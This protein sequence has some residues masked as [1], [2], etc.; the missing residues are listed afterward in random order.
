MK[1]RRTAFTLVELLVVIAIIGILIALLLPAVQAAREAA[2][3]SQCNNN[4]KQ[5]ALGLLNY[6]DVHSQFPPR[7]MGTT[8]FMGNVPKGGKVCGNGNAAHCNENRLSTRV[9]LLPYIEQQALW[10]NIRGAGIPGF[11]PQGPVPWHTGYA[12]WLETIPA[13]VCPSETFNMSQN[14]YP[15]ARSNYHFSVGDT[16]STNLNTNGGTIRGMFGRAIKCSLANVLDGTSNT[17]MVAERCF[18][19]FTKS[20]SFLD[21]YPVKSGLYAVT[22]A[23]IPANCL[24]QAA[25]MYYHPGTAF[26]A[27]CNIT[28]GSNRWPDGDPPY[29]SFSTILPPNS[30]NCV[31]N[32]AND[33]DH[34]MISSVSSNHPGGALVAMADGSVRF[35]NEGID[36]GMLTVTEVTSG[37]SPYG[38]W[39]S[40]GS[41]DGGEGR[42]DTQQF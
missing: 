39:G 4:Q 10:D 5:I 13:Y 12:P 32:G 34:P 33:G 26:A 18:T 35:V 40:L 22:N 31:I 23:A 11:L 16:L 17:A 25:G 29:S 28:W 37:P 8:G 38:V 6:H 24:A 30:P 42:T 2:R 15:V 1:L 20:K 19:Y 21:K 27:C 14:L 36:C 3:R 41:K 9:F 7:S